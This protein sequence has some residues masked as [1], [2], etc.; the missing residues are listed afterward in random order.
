M[1]YGYANVMNMVIARLVSAMWA[2]PTGHCI[3]IK[4]DLATLR[5]HGA[6]AQK[7]VDAGEKTRVLFSTKLLRVT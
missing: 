5:P 1:T 4:M 2:M 6:R 3:P 7:T